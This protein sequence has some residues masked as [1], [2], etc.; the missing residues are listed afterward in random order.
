MN[1]AKLTI[2]VTA[3]FTSSIVLRDNEENL[4]A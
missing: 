3:G 1:T 2:N 4:F